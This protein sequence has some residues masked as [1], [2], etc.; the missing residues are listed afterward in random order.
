[1]P[2]IKDFDIFSAHTLGQYNILNST[3][4]T[5]HTLADLTYDSVAISIWQHQ[6]CHFYQHMCTAIGVYRNHLLEQTLTAFSD[7]VTKLAPQE[8]DGLQVP[9]ISYFHNASADSPRKIISNLIRRLD[10]VARRDTIISWSVLITCL[11]GNTVNIPDRFENR[12]WW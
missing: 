3:C 2:A 11:V 9:L 4:W 10:I 12:G 8:Q 1:M 6:L 7:A 5:I